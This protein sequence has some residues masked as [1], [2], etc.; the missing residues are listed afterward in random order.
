MKYKLEE[1][2][3]PE[4]FLL[5]LCSDG[6]LELMPQPLVEQK[7]ESLL[8]MVNDLALTPKEIIAGLGI[9]EAGDNLPDDVTLLSVGR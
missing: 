3:L 1:I 7:E 2:D 4:H 6:V 8:A 9:G 5:V